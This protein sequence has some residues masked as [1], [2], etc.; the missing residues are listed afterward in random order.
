MN[1]KKVMTKPK[2]KP[3]AVKVKAYGLKRI[4]GSLVETAYRTKELAESWA[5]RGEG[6]EVIRVSIKEIK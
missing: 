6:L 5:W 2:N 3:K 1:E 4:D